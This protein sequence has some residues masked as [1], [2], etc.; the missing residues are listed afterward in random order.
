MEQ[1]YKLWLDD[2]RPPIA[3]DWVWAKNLDE[4]AQILSTKGIPG[5]VSL[6]HDL[7]HVHYGGDYSDK[8]TG[9]EAALLLARA[10]KTTAKPFVHVHTRN[11]HRAPLMWQVLNQYEFPRVHPSF[12]L[13]IKNHVEKNDLIRALEAGVIFPGMN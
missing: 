8:Q 9:Y 7:S 12:A 3:P 5:M 6:D 2:L 10:T 1:P 11:T 4:F 13:D